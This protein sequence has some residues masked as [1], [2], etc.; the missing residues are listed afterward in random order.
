MKFGTDPMIIIAKNHRRPNRAQ[1]RHIE[2]LLIVVLDNLIYLNL[3]GVQLS[4]E[5]SQL[6]SEYDI[7]SLVIY[8]NSFI[9]ISFIN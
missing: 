9:L 7:D 2:I 3:D 5:H 4:L 8:S 1:N 6:I